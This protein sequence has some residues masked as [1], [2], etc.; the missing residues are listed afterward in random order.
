MTLKVLYCVL[1][2]VLMFTFC[3]EMEK[4]KPSCILQILRSII[5]LIQQE[6]NNFIQV[7]IRYCIL[8]GGVGIILS[9]IIFGFS[10]QHLISG[11]KFFI[12]IN[13]CIYRVKL[14]NPCHIQ[15]DVQFSSMV[16]KW[17]KQYVNINQNIFIYQQY[18]MRIII[19]IYTGF[20]NLS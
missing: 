14:I 4:W 12:I 11:V 18:N 5:N 6:N 2:P 9:C 20:F 8:F 13:V 19:R 1:F 7:R 3:K 15:N 16:N 17:N 10:L